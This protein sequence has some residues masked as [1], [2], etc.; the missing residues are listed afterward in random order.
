MLTLKRI[1]T[2]AV[3]VY[4]LLALLFILAPSVRSSLM[5]LSNSLS[6]LAKE[7]NF[8]YVMFVVGAIVLAL[9][10]V[11]ENL[12]SLA[13]RRTVSKHESKINELKAKIYDNQQQA[14]L[15]PD[16][17]AD[18]LPAEPIVRPAY[19]PD[20]PAPPLPPTGPTPY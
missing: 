3:M 14:T 9:H 18:P 13:L 1:V 19:P 6:D 2:V 10:L 11:T 12:D 4:L 8:F 17:H 5:G 20:E 15:V 7:R 16:A